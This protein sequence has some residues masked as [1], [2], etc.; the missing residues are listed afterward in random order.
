MRY[1]Q[2]ITILVVLAFNGCASMLT[3]PR[4]PHLCE[5]HGVK[6]HWTLVPTNY[7]LPY[8]PP[9]F[10]EAL[11]TFPYAARPVNHGCIVRPWSRFN[12]RDW[13]RACPRCTEAWRAWIH[14]S[15]SE[16][17]S[18]TPAPMTRRGPAPH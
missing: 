12:K 3:A 7:G 16:L 13:V 6:L 8:F 18:P 2:A 4:R 15:V 17:D 10:R 14:D 1:L 5:V 9:G 11:K